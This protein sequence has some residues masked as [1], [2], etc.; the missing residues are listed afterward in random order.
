MK[1][2][3]FLIAAIA[4]SFLG[5]FGAPAFAQKVDA[6]HSW[7]QNEM[8]ESACG[9]DQGFVG[10]WDAPPRRGDPT[11]VG[12]DPEFCAN[13]RAAAAKRRIEAA[14]AQAEAKRAE[15]AEEQW[16]RWLARQPKDEPERLPRECGNDTPDGE[17]KFP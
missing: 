12:G 14:L 17:V 16:E 9:S 10:A 3:K 15:R 8:F 11:L 1:A 4:A 13:Y 6:P 2:N 7:S 5:G